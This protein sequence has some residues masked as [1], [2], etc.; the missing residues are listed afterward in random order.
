MSGIR[1]VLPRIRKLQIQSHKNNNNDAL[2]TS[3]KALRN[4]NKLTLILSSLKRERDV[5][6][7]MFQTVHRLQYP[8]F[9]TV[10][11]SQTV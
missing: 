3:N 9:L 6:L 8:T 11:I 2:L 4:P 7:Q 10:N 1:D 5:I